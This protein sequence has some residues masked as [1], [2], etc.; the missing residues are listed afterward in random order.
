MSEES[1]KQ[2]AIA[3]MVVVLLVLGMAMSLSTI[4]DVARCQCNKEAKP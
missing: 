3:F 1:T 4:R 2:L